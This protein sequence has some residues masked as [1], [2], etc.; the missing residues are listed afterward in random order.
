MPLWLVT[1]RWE[2]NGSDIKEWVV[3]GEDAISAL[4]QCLKNYPQIR[5]WYVKVVQKK[6]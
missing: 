3:G 5:P 4:S 1:V 6:V 2:E